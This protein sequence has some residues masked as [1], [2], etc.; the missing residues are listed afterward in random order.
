MCFRKEKN[1]RAI[2]KRLEKAIDSID[3]AVIDDGIIGIVSFL[4]KFCEEAMNGNL[5]ISLLTSAEDYYDHIS[6]RLDRASKQQLKD[7]VNAQKF[8]ASLVIRALNTAP[9]MGLDYLPSEG[10]L[11]AD[12][13][14]LSE[15]DRVLKEKMDRALFCLQQH[16]EKGGL[17]LLKEVCSIL[18]DIQD[19]IDINDELNL[20]RH[21]YLARKNTSELDRASARIFSTEE[22]D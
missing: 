6:I 1:S 19:S 10:F 22:D 15:K 9:A 11:F 4:Q 21:A 8:Y 2:R 14:P 18:K 3:F 20:A 5:D 12:I 17:S 16:S 7:L 13:A